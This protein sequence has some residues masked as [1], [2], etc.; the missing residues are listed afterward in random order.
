[1]TRPSLATVVAI[2]L[3]LLTVVVYS[4]GVSNG[5]VFDDARL[6]D[7]TIAQSYG[8][9]WPV[10]QRLLSYGSFVWVVS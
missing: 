2:L 5:L 4:L 9:L 1:M 8:S 7:G 10:K 3:A 6:A